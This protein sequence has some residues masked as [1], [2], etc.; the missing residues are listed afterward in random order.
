MRLIDSI[1]RSSAD[2]SVVSAKVAVHVTSTYFLCVC[3][4][5]FTFARELPI[6]TRR[7]FVKASAGIF[8]AS[9]G[10]DYRNAE[11]ERRRGIAIPTD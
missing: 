7:Q 5:V 9:L 1:V 6:R 10:S 4:Y 8:I 3:V 11:G 2:D